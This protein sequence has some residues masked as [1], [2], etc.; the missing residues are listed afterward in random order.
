MSSHGKIERVMGVLTK[1]E[2]EEILPR[3][4]YVNGLTTTGTEW[5]KARSIPPE[6]MAVQN[7]VVICEW[8]GYD[9]VLLEEICWARCHRWMK[10]YDRISYVCKLQNVVSF[11]FV[12]FLLLS[13][14]F[15]FLMDLSKVT[16]DSYIANNR[17]TWYSMGGGDVI[18]S[19][20]VF[21]IRWTPDGGRDLSSADR[22]HRSPV[23]VVFMNELDR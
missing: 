17:E 10:G 21:L 16:E 18:P 3:D 23:V 19:V 5:T 6:W 13:F 12:A 14:F 9:L 2:R 4:S 7:G 8:N 20:N 15:A 1:L 11:P 22:L